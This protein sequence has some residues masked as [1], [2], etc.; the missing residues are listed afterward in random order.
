[1]ELGSKQTARKSTGGKQPRKHIV[2]RS[3]R[4]PPPPPPPGVSKRAAKGPRAAPKKGFRFR[5]GTVALREI[6]RYQR[7]TEALIRKLPFQR[8]VRQILQRNIL[9][10]RRFFLNLFSFFSQRWSTAPTTAFRPPRWKLFRKRA[11]PTWSPC[12]RTRTCAPSTLNESRSCRATSSSPAV[13]EAKLVA[14]KFL[15]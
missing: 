10:P 5:P 15:R 1:M 4:K 8:L 7:S 3:P 11:R 13:S 9:T 2:S 6:R 14:E 12:S